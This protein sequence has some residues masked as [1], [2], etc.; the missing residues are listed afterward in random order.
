MNDCGIPFLTGVNT[1]GVTLHLRAAGAMRAGIFSTDTHR[2]DA[3]KMVRESISISGA[4]LVSEVT[5]K[6]F[7]IIV[8]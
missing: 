7:N 8:T 2:E 4:D 1:R 3:L 6:N 5:S